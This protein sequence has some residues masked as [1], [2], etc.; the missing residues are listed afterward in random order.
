MRAK[1]R[2]PRVH[3]R[4]TFLAGLAREGDALRLHPKRGAYR[5]TTDADGNVLADIFE[6]S[7]TLFANIGDRLI[8][9]GEPVDEIAI[10]H[11]ASVYPDGDLRFAV[12]HG[13]LHERTAAVYVLPAGRAR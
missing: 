6:P 9:A 1:A 11:V 2:K 12:A 13:Q 5:R 3:A 10:G 7:A 4:Q 8:L